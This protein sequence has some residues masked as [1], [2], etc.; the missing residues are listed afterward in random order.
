MWLRA[1]VACASACV[2]LCHL[3]GSR[4]RFRFDGFHRL[5][6]FHLLTTVVYYLCTLQLT[7]LS[8]ILTAFRFRAAFT[9]Y[10]ALKDG[11][12][13]NG[14]DFEYTVNTDTPYTVSTTGDMGGCTAGE[15]GTCS[16]TPAS[17]DNKNRTV[18]IVA[19]IP[20][21]VKFPEGMTPSFIEFKMCFAAASTVDRKWRKINDLFKVCLLKSQ[22]LKFSDNIST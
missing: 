19:T 8:F 16:E 11:G 6:E 12:Y 4:H 3:N 9:K 20:A 13:V 7:Q 18:E 21:G 15:L 2:P 10:S 14:F 17:W 5:I 22:V 1:C